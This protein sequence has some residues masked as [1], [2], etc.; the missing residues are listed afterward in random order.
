MKAQKFIY[1]V[2][3]I[4]NSILVFAQKQQLFIQGTITSADSNTV[5]QEAIVILTKNGNTLQTNSNAKGE[6]SFANLS[7]GVYNIYVYKKNYLTYEQT[8]ILLS[9]AKKETKIHIELKNSNSMKPIITQRKAAPLR[10]YTRNSGWNTLITAPNQNINIIAAYARGV[11]SRNG[12]TP[13][14][15]G[16]RPEGT[17]YYIDGVRIANPNTGEIIIGKH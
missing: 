6:F 15:R 17:A 2:F 14:I 3:F 12:E 9:Q 7:E 16:A 8:H 13:I 10:Y 5:I 1:L 4:I 11:D